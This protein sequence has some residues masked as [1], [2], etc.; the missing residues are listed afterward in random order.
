MLRG[1]YVPSVERIS[2]S[3]LPSFTAH[4][5]NFPDPEGVADLR[6]QCGAEW[7][8]NWRN[9]KLYGIPKVDRPQ[10]QIGRPQTLT[11]G[12]ANDHD[13]LHLLTARLTDQLPEKF[14]E[15]HVLRQR[16]FLF[17]GKKNEIVTAATAGWR[18][19]DELVHHFK[20]NPTFEL[21]SRIIEVRPRDVQVA[22]CLS[23]H[24]R[25]SIHAPL[26]RLVNAGIDL[27]G[28]HVVRRDP[29]EQRRLVGRIARVS[30]EMVELAEA[31]DDQ[32]TIPVNEV[33]LEGRRDSFSRCLRHLLGQRYE[34][35]DDARSNEESKL[36]NGPA[37]HDVLTKMQGYLWDA[38]P[39]K[40]T[41]DLTCDI[42]GVI[43]LKNTS[44]FNTAVWL[45]AA[46]YCFDPAKAQRS[47]YA[48]PGLERYGPFDRETFSK[49][50]PRI[51]VVAPDIAAGK[52]SQFVKMFRD[53]ITSLPGSRYEKGFAR[54]FGFVNPDF[55]SCA[56]PLHGSGGKRPC[57]L[58]KQA[59]A[60]HLERDPTYDA[61]LVAI[62]DEHAL[63]PDEISPYLYAKAALLMAG[64]P[65][66]LARLST[67]TKGPKNLQYTMQNIATAMY[68]KLG[69]VPWTV[70]QDQTVDDE[71]VVGMG[72]AEVSGSRFEARQRH[73]G[74]TTVFQGDGNY[75]LSNLSRECS[76][77]DY[78]E[79]LRRSMLAVL[80]EVKQRN[81]WRAGETVRVVFHATKP[82]RNVEVAGI[83][84]SCVKEV[85]GEQTVQFAFLT[86]NTD[87]AFKLIDP[88]Q[89]GMPLFRGSDQ[90][91]G[92]MAPERGT[93]V[94]LGRY[95]RLVST[96]GPRLI[97]K[98]SSPLPTPLLIHLHKQSTYVDQTYLSEQ[99]LKFTA[100]SWRSV[101][102]AERPVTI[103]YS[104]LI[105]DLLVRLRAV[106]GWSAMGLNAKL[107]ASKWFL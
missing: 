57:D 101:L 31:Y 17:V 6:R 39:V 2:R 49:R 69:G 73:I 16:P 42:S 8:L 7:F 53:G 19:L 18:D 54:T 85:C 90:M 1:Q 96:N 40:L 79:V 44:T 77:E 4:V 38:S 65:A 50:T 24:T 88:D 87:H 100:L 28:L 10:R 5:T 48:W 95:T 70:D 61:A 82:L 30:G 55:V 97:K 107:R 98:A 83:V 33:W 92:V 27:G 62:P 36:L 103:Y 104:E 21:D 80:D 9:G 46:R 20:I 86:V 13:H 84:D 43:D 94:Q 45:K 25:W 75:L 32:R 41:A 35:F 89:P 26:D 72:T 60:E 99:V 78:P 52:V 51:L 102:P 14:P 81:R 106:P 76:Y 67:L 11:W 105:A 23:I 3:V 59:V 93:L 34:R 58:Y 68:A 71:I 74:I 47:D 56:V 64:L 22:L 12:G 91:K 66:Q 29:A 37:L 15:R 63:L